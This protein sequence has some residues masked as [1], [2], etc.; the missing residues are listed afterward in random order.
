MTDAP[1]QPTEAP[2]AAGRIA[3]NARAQRMQEIRH[4]LGGDV[5]GSGCENCDEH[6][7]LAEVDRLTA[8][9]EQA[10]DERDA[11]REEV[12]AQDDETTLRAVQDMMTERAHYVRE[13][14]R[15]AES[16]AAA[17]DERRAA[18]EREAT[19]YRRRADT[20]ERLRTLRAERSEWLASYLGAVRLAERSG[21]ERDEARAAL[22]AKDDAVKALLGHLH[23]GWCDSMASINELD[24]AC[25]LR[26]KIDRALL[27]A[28]DHAT[29]EDTGDA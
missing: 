12:G 11:I 22:A 6:I 8:R 21:Q 20:I 28:P 17:E 4:W 1:D 23:H 16:L 10:E 18:Q 15:M 24:C 3:E 26:G 14:N 27:A 5:Q 2:D 29:Q 19:A 25:G 9:Y 13:C 7:L